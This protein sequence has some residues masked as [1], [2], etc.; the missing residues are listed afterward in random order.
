VPGEAAAAAAASA[1]SGSLQNPKHVLPYQPLVVAAND[2]EQR[3][4]GN[5]LVELLVA[6]WLLAAGDMSDLSD[7]IM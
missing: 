1:P 7:R 3:R 5:L 2:Q 4:S 6:C